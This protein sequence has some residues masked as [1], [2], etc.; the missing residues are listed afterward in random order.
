MLSDGVT[1][2]R[3][4]STSPVAPGCAMDDDSNGSIALDRFSFLEVLEV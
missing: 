3:Q 1:L 4:L 2:D